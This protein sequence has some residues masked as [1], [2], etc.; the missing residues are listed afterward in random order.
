MAD[1]AGWSYWS[2][3]PRFKP[4]AFAPIGNEADKAGNAAGQRLGTSISRG[5]QGRLS[6]LATKTIAPLAGAIAGIKVVDFFKDAVS[7]ASDLN[8]TVSLNKVIFKEDAAEILAWSKTSAQAFG[9]SRNA[10]LTATGQFGDMFN[11]LGFG[12]QE[13]VK[14]SKEVVGLAADLGSFKNLKTEDVL[15]RISAGFRGE[16]DSL[17]LLIPNIN[18]ARVQKEALAKTGKK[19]AAA[20]TAEEKAAATLAII[21]KDGAAAHGD[22]ARTSDD[23]AGSTKTLSAEW[24]DAKAEIGQGLLP[25]MKDATHFLTDEGVPAFLK[26][27]DEVGPIAKDVL[28]AV[29][30]G[31]KT[32][33][34]LGKPLVPIVKGVADGFGA[35]PDGAQKVAVLAGAV[36]LLKRHFDLTI[37]SMASFRNEA[38][39]ASAKSFAMKAGLGAAGLG[40]LELSSRA[41]GATTDLGALTTVAGSIAAG[42]AFG[43]W[44]AVVGGAS[45]LLSVFGAR[46]RA[47]ADAQKELVTQGKLVAETLDDQTGALT[48]NTRQMI[49]KQ[50]ADNGAFEA[51]TKMGISLGDV[52]RAAEGNKEALFNVTRGMID[53][54]E[55][56]SGSFEQNLKT[57][58]TV[59]KLGNAIGVTTAEIEKER[60]GI[61]QVGKAM[62]DLDGKKAD[63]KVTANTKAAMAAIRG[64]FNF[65]DS[66]PFIN[67]NTKGFATGGWT[68]PG[69]KHEPA[70]IVHRDEFVMRKE[71][72]QR[73]EASRP[74]ALDHANRTGQW[75]GYANGGRVGGSASPATSDVLQIVRGKLS[76]DE[77]GQAWIEGV[78]QRVVDT[79]D[80]RNTVKSRVPGAFA[81][82]PA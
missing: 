62:D 68:G 66:L 65:A 70:G 67:V 48:E 34:D 8:E 77:S 69:S 29:G 25:A 71:A 32:A 72:R 35:L 5:T 75:P 61:T 50:Y 6:S 3:V 78:A 13:S 15:E 80:Y 30:E 82:S 46:S 31:F 47:A 40:L 54:A 57:A 2:L 58:E 43:P 45:G 59:G 55:A 53:Y 12:R 18:A 38:T 21:T 17:Q 76:I 33:A 79:N 24:A 36:L 7:G 4:G 73:L 51:A 23:L 41:G 56:N 10:A 39:Q 42:A 19:N 63:V 44:G 16:Y 20:L 11:Q 81:G 64:L 28:P 22:F 37:P 74:G 52:T 9:L 27:A 49:L 26:L 60:R 14:L 1:E